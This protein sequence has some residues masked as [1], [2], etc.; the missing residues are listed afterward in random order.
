MDGAGAKNSALPIL[1]LM[2]EKELNIIRKKQ[3]REAVSAHLEQR[4][5][6]INEAAVFRKVLIKYS[7]LRVRNKISY[8]AFMKNITVYQLFY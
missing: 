5:I 3:K 8:M 2:K 1:E 7:L 6:H 4:I